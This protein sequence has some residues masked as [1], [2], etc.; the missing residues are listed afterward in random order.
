MRVT[1]WILCLI[2]AGSAFATAQVTVK[3]LLNSEEEQQTQTKQVADSSTIDDAMPIDEFN[4]GTP[5]STMQSYLNAAR[6]QDFALA[7]NYLDY[8]NVNDAVREV[9][10]E[11]L[12]E[13]LFLVLNRTLW[14][15][16]EQLSAHPKGK[17]EEFLP[18]YRDLVGEIKTSQGPVQILLQ[19]VPGDKANNYIWK[20]SNA[21]VNNLLL[22]RDEY[23]YSQAGK[24][25]YKHL[26]DGSLLGVK[27][28]QW[29]YY[30]ANFVL[31]VF[32]AFIITQLAVR[33]FSQFKPDLSQEFKTLI[34]GPACLL[35]GV[36]LARYFA[37]DANSTLASKALFE[38]AT[39]LIIAWTW[40]AV[41]FVDVVRYRY[42]IALQK[43]GNDQAVYLLRPLANVVKISVVIF[44]SFMWLE[45]LGFSVTTLLAGLGI[46]G[47]AVALAA[48]KSV[49]NIIGAITLYSSAPVKI[50]QLCRFGDQLGTVE[51]IG[52]RATRIRTLN[53]SVIH[54]PNARFVDMEL[55]NISERERIAYRPECVF[56]SNTT[57]QQV[58]QF[59]TQFKSLLQSQDDFSDSPCRVRFVGFVPRG[60]HIDV[61]GYLETTDFNTYVARNDELN[62]AMLALIEKLGIKLAAPEHY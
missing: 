3:D 45:N 56:D 26:P 17:N 52:L 49:E 61:L 13:I 31:F 37:S 5:R 32:V 24:W 25:L 14:V 43:R 54:V 8:R 7:S 33:I 34:G 55:E 36:I 50:G 22:L 1:V 28:W 12:A 27:L 23:E 4:R 58:A 30:S 2:F 21:T 35:L 6:V 9:G 15:D 59:Q 46:G 29:V 51:E 18:S 53:R 19:R 47:L 42:G 11:Q 44:A 40:F 48:Q 20:I 10:E 38:G 60:L 62:L 41:R 39:L 16:L 57:S